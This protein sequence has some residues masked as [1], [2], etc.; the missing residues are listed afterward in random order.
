MV[1]D[2]DPELIATLPVQ[3]PHEAKPIA[4]DG[5]G[6][7]YVTIGAPSN[8]CQ[9]EPRTPGSPGLRPCPQLEEHAG[10]WRFDADTPDQTQDNG[11]MRYATGIRNAVALRWNNAAGAL[12]AVQHGRDQ[13]DQL[14]PEYFVAEQNDE[15]PAEEFFRIEEGDNFGWPYCYYNWQTEQKLL[16]PEYGG[17]GETVGE[18]DQY[19]PPIVAFP[20]HWAP[21]DL[22]FVEGTQFPPAYRGGALIA[23]HGSWNRL[24]GAGQRGY[25]VSFVPFEN[26]APSGEPEIF[27]D[28]FIGQDDP[29]LNPNGAAARPVGLAQGPDGTLYVADSKNGR[30]WR[31]I[32]TGETSQPVA[33]AGE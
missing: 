30:I 3:G 9:E 20:G 29:I 25:N 31:V 4:F 6:N 11:G 1:L 22:L 2:G 16:N 17:D 33:E 13:L 5:Q 18:C 28:G 19:K 14:W 26:G 23:F 7:V 32:Y 21:N 12:F 8:A 24:S 10:I 27:I 15:L